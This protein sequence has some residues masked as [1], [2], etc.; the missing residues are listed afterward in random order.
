MKFC[1]VCESNYRNLYAIHMG[2]K[3]HQRKQFVLTYYGGRV[4]R[5]SRRRSI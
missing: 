3:K 4:R 5:G 1:Y 2:T